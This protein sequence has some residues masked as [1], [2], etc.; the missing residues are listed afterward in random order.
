MNWSTGRIS[1]SCK[2]KKNNTR[3]SSAE[4]RSHL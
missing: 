1:S 3:Y 2:L 4:I